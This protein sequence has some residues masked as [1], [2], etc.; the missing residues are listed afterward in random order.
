MTKLAPHLTF[1]L[2]KHLPTER[3]YSP[4]TVQ[5]YTEC[6]RLLVSYASAHTSVR[7]C[8]LNIEH[9][10]VQLVIEFLEYL[11]QSRANT[12]ATRNIR[13]ATI[14]SFFRYLEYRVPSCLDLAMHIR[15][16]R[17]KRA[18]QPLIDWLEPIEVQAIV[19]ATANN[20]AAG[21]RDR[22]MLHLCYAAALRV[23]EL[24]TL[25]LDSF[26]CPRMETIQIMGKGRRQRI[27][28]LWQNTREHLQN[29][30][31]LRPAT[32]T[33]RLLFLN[34]RGHPLSTDGFTYILNRHVI[35]A[36]KTVPSLNDK[37]I[38]PHVLRHSSAIAV[39]RA[40][41]DIRKV[42]L[43]LGH[44]NIQTTE[45]YLRANLNTKLEILGTNLPA[46]LE[47]GSFSEVEDELMRFLIGR[48]R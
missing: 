21:L 16:I 26:S 1:F 43:W 3:N 4:H 17:P 42:S 40:T 19:E 6:F 30:L 44:A 34:A 27:I 29:W 9:L 15:A 12:V 38:T 47:P 7:P 8:A 33:N 36:A 48:C 22:A 14:K 10:T 2:G 37:H 32:A 46:S 28:P 31:H 45:M 23:S 13:L 20:T 18:S 5:S 41:K 25:S 35:T 24:V 11:E 39:L